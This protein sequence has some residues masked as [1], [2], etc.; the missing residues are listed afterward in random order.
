M[1]PKDLKYAATHEWVALDGDLATVG[2]SA[3]AVEQLTDLIMIDLAKAK[4]GATLTA[5]EPFGEV[6]SVKSVNDIY[7]PISGEVVEVNAAV[8]DDVGALAASP[9]GTGW[10]LK[11]RPSAPEAD[12]AKLLDHDAYQ[13]RIADDAH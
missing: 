2:I 4:A 9:F 1:D 5:G 7:A 8:L 11:L 3:F 6:E 13:Q 12:L 10:L